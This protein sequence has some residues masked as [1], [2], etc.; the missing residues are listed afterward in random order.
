MLPATLPPVTPVVVLARFAPAPADWL[1]AHR[2][3]DLAATPGQTVRS[4]AACRIAFTG[5]VAGR[6]VVSLAC[7]G[8]RY[9]FEPVRSRRAAGDPVRAGGPVGT[10]GHGGHCDARC[11]HWGAKIGGHYMDP[12]A[13]LPRRAPVLKPVVR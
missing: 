13:L 9:T 6:P 11:I 5:R 12:L 4:P 3:V 8:V 10:V 2:G 1:P 7:H